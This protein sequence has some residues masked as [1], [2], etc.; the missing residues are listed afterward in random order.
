[1]SIWT[2]WMAWGWSEMGRTDRQRQIEKARKAASGQAIRAL[3]DA[4]PGEY[5][6]L[7]DAQRAAGA[8]GQ[9][10]NRALAELREAHRDEYDLLHEQAKR[11]FG[12]ALDPATVAVCDRCNRTLPGGAF[13]LDPAAGTP[14]Q[15]CRECRAET[16]AASQQA[17]SEA[18]HAAA[19]RLREV[20]QA[21]HRALYGVQ[22][23]SDGAR[24]VAALVELTRRHP[25]EFAGLNG[26]ERR[27]RGLGPVGTSGVRRHTNITHTKETPK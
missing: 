15:P 9:S 22:V 20:H 12:L 10:V 25:A 17:I 16:L 4:H 23:G 5:E 7:R 18:W 3:R 27:R 14:K 8:G 26:Q 13:P 19:G 11:Q 2:I 1:M 6:A 24:W 21:E